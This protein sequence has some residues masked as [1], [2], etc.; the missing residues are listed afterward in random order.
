MQLDQ[1]FIDTDILEDLSYQQ[2]RFEWAKDFLLQFLVDIFPLDPDS[3]GS[4]MK[5]KM[6]NQNRIRI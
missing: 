1:S 2:S 5:K 4:I 3:Y 6:R